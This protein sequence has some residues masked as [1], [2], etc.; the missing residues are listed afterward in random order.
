MPPVSEAMRSSRWSLSALR[1]ATLCACHSCSTL[2]SILT[3]SILKSD[4]RMMVLSL[5]TTT[6]DACPRSSILI[7]L[8]SSP[9]FSLKYVAPTLTARSCISSCCLYPKLGGCTTHIFRLF[10]I[11]FAA[12]VFTTFTWQGATISNF[13]PSVMIGFSTFSIC[14]MLPISMSATS[15]CTSSNTHSSRL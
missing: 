15:T 4:L 11:T 14:K 2:S 1:L 3:P 6:L 10:F 13:F 9:V 8:R 12:S 7:W 5:L